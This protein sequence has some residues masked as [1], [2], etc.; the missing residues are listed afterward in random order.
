[1]PNIF[2][3]KMPQQYIPYLWSKVKPLSMLPQSKLKIKD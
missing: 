3:E 1:M 2:K